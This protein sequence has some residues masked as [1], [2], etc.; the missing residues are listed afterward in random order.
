M[1][2]ADVQIVAA[3]GTGEALSQARGGGSQPREMDS[4]LLWLAGLALIALIVLLTVLY[5]ARPLLARVAPSANER[6]LLALLLLVS[7]MPGLLPVPGIAQI[8]AVLATYL[9]LVN[10]S[11]IVGALEGLASLGQLMGGFQRLPT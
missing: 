4:D 8:L 3:A 9:L 5:S 7:C 2:L 10:Y 1:A 11:R 6:W